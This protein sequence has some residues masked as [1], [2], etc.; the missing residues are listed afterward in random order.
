MRHR[1]AAIDGL[2]TDWTQTDADRVRA[3]VSALR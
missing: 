2:E 3:L 1:P